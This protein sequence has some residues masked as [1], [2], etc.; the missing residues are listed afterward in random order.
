MGSETIEH[1]L[2][3]EVAKLF[4]FLLWCCHSL[5]CVWLWIGYFA[6]SNTGTHWVGPAPRSSSS[7]EN[8]EPAQS[9]M[10]MPELGVD[11]E[12]SL[13]CWLEDNVRSPLLELDAK[14]EQRLER[15]QRDLS[16]LAQHAFSPVP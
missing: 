1:P 11:S 7:G 16:Q 15:L 3:L 10:A 6:P 14:L 12:P 9:T 5:G 13:R 8:L 4:L 2:I